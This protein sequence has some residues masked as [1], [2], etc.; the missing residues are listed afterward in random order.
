MNPEQK[1]IPAQTKQ[2]KTERPPQPK[3]SML[4]GKYLRLKEIDSKLK[5]Q[6]KVIFGYEKKRGKLKKELSECT[7]IF[8]GGRRKELQQEID[9]IDIQISNMKKRFSSIVKDY[10]FDSVQA[11]YKEFN[12]AKREYLD[13][14]AAC[15]EYEKIYGDKVM[16]AMSVRDRLRKKEQMVKEREAGRMHQTRQKDKGAR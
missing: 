4:A 5:D 12:A 10:G 7:G 11:F 2:L 13:Y 15:A 14:K 6:N 3:P 8:K 9:S 1:S 16:D